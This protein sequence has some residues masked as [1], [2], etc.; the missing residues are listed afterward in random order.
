MEE[1]PKWCCEICDNGQCVMATC[2]WEALSPCCHHHLAQADISL[3]ALTLNEQ[4][5]EQE[6]GWIVQKTGTV[7][8]PRP[9]RS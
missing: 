4:K 3:Q 2:H 1:A 6:M 7:I 9:C 5:D 8:R